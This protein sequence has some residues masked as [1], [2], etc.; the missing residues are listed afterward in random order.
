MYYAYAQRTIRKDMLTCSVHFFT[1]RSRQERPCC[2]FL[3]IIPSAHPTK[4]YISHV[5]NSQ[6]CDLLTP[7]PCYVACRAQQHKSRRDA[8]HLIIY[9]EINTLGK[10]SA[11][12]KV[13]SEVDSLSGIVSDCVEQHHLDQSKKVYA[14]FLC[15]R[16]LMPLI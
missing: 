12:L 10:S 16:Y 7:S 2:R 3:V 14:C 15:H 5:S 6:L 8:S 9:T 4:T 11:H 13:Y 1:F